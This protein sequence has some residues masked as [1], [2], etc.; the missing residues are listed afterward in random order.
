[1]QAN[2]KYEAYYD[3][4]EGYSEEQSNGSNEET[5]SKLDLLIEVM[6]ETQNLMNQ[7]L[8][9]N[10]VDSINNS[11]IIYNQQPDS[12]QSLN[13]LITPQLTKSFFLFV[14]L[15]GTFLTNSVSEYFSYSQLS[16][17]QKENT[18]IIEKKVIQQTAQ[19]QQQ[20]S[21]RSDIIEQETKQI[22]T[23]LDNVE[24]P[25]EDY[26]LEIELLKKE[27]EQLK[28]LKQLGISKKY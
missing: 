15:A 5:N 25:L 4:Y 20:V 16:N 19:I 28:R 26:Q 7:Q 13:N 21:K 24:E 10:Q 3:N 8:D 6:Y 23:E 17:D 11:E 27:L 22:I 18:E 1:M 14:T 9:N 2:P 12:K